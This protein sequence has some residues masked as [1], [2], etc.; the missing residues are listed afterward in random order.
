MLTLDET[1]IIRRSHAGDPEAFTPLVGK[2]QDR[3]YRHIR[4]RVTDPEI[5]EDLTQETWLRAFRAISSFRGGSAFYSW[6]YRIAENV[7]IDHFRRQKYNTEPLHLVDE[8]RITETDPCPSRAV[9]RAEL[10]EHLQKALTALTATRRRV[11]LLY[12]YHELPI[13]AIAAEIG[14]S[15]GTVKSHLR[16][17]RLQLRELLTPY[18][19]NR[20]VPWLA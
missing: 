13:K 14:R 10:R 18:V 20:H 17:A 8:N 19:E 1:D 7:C 16:N 5:A 11:F 9:E 15:E 12:Y 4:R 3:L 2:Y 6:L